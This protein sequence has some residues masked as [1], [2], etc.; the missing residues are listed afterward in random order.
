M[1][2]NTHNS[3]FSPPI[4]FGYRSFTY[5]GVLPGAAYDTAGNY[6]VPIP[7]TDALQITK[8]LPD[9]VAPIL[10]S[11]DINLNV[12]P[13]LL[14]LT[15]NE[16]VDI[17]TF[18]VT[19]ITLQ[20]RFLASSGRLYRLTGGHVRTSSSSNEITDDDGENSIS[21]AER[22]I[23]DVLIVELT[24][25]DVNNMKR[26]GALLRN[27][28]SSFLVQ[29]A[30]VSDLAGNIVTSTLDGF[31]LS[32]RTYTADSTAPEIVYSR[33]DMQDGT[34]SLSFNEPVILSSVVV[35]GLTLVSTRPTVHYDNIQ[36]APYFFYRLTTSTTASI[37]PS[38]AGIST[39]AGL[40][41]N[42]TLTFSANDLD[43]IKRRYPLLSSTVTSFLAPDSKF[44][45]DYVLN[46][47]TQRNYQHALPVSSYEI[48]RVAPKVIAYSLNMQAQP[49]YVQL[50]LSECIDIRTV[51]PDQLYLQNFA[52]R[53]FGQFVTLQDA[54]VWLGPFDSQKMLRT[55]SATASST[56]TGDASVDNTRVSTSLGALLAMPASL[57]TQYAST[58]ANLA[59]STDDCRILTFL[60]PDEVVKYM[61]AQGIGY[62][63]SSG[64]LTFTTAFLRDHADNTIQPQYDGAVV[65]TIASA[66][67]TT[68]VRPYPPLAPTTLILDTQ[69]PV[70]TR[71]FY[72]PLTQTLTLDFTEPILF[73]RG[74]NTNS[75]AQDSTESSIYTIDNNGESVSVPGGDHFRT[76]SGDIVY[77]SDLYFTHDTFFDNTFTI[78][79][80]STSSAS[81]GNNREVSIS[82]ASPDGSFTTSFSTRTTEAIANRLEQRTS[83]SSTKHPILFALPLL[84]FVDD[85]QDATSSGTNHTN[86]NTSTGIDMS[87]SGLQW[88]YSQDRTRAQVT[89]TAAQHAY[90]LTY[91]TLSRLLLTAITQSHFYGPQRNLIFLNVTALSQAD[92]MS[93]MSNDEFVRGHC[94]RNL[95]SGAY[96][97]V[98]FLAYLA[99]SSSPSS[100]NAD[101]N[102]NRS[103]LLGLVLGSGYL[104][105]DV[106][107]A[108]NWLAGTIGRSPR[109]AKGQYL[110]PV[111]V[112]LDARND[113]YQLDA[114]DPGLG[115][116]LPGAPGKC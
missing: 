90:C 55:I 74:N 103:S 112:A 12:N 61:K 77:L 71:W 108:G 68:K 78:S 100:R 114:K 60:L 83:P 21:V 39:S 18:N 53:R 28:A 25:F 45:G 63:E 84:V 2:H 6:L 24:T 93:M 9:T 40:S 49:L 14:T 3:F 15:F 97:G 11:F 96:E 104:V 19:A 58:N 88:V 110:S 1:C 29:R 42:I 4:F 26:S 43:Q 82:T 37:T 89:L 113:N 59:T 75:E 48:D 41:E 47:I 80:T 66:P 54:F 62:D 67:Q 115:Y 31:A 51:R 33:V 79:V 34:L 44:V 106:S 35:S 27:A 91:T 92:R 65:N 13:V 50:T 111:D 7:Y 73:V 5:L 94:P 116:L 32:C 70:V 8:F 20:S 105:Q 81:T 72:D 85:P 57:E 56:I 10:T 64:F 17:E 99:N 22:A 95:F 102:N 109:N 107:A 46:G 30:L 38:T 101:E 76:D 23:S 16:A 36:Q 86:T 87:Q 98:D 52:T 69:K